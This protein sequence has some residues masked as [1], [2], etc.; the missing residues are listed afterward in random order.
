MC[1]RQAALVKVLICA[2]LVKL[3]IAYFYLKYNAV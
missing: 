2:L 1:C 3:V